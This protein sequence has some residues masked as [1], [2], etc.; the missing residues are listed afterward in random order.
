MIFLIRHK[1]TFHEIV[2]MIHDFQMRKLK[3]LERDR[4][5]IR[6]H[7]LLREN[8]AWEG[9]LWQSEQAGRLPV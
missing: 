3:R 9:T 1:I 5:W 2:V 4:V 6:D 7:D 8:H